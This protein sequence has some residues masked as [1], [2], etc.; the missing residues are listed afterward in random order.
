MS[1]TAKQMQNANLFCLNKPYSLNKVNMIAIDMI[2]L[3]HAYICNNDHDVLSS[4]RRR[5]SNIR[6]AIKKINKHDSVSI[7]DNP[8]HEL[9]TCHNNMSPYTYEALLAAYVKHYS[10][11]HND[12]VNTCIFTVP[13]MFDHRILANAMKLIDMPYTTVYDYIAASYIMSTQIKSMFTV[14]VPNEYETTIATVNNHSFTSVH[15]IPFGA[16]HI[17]EVIKEFIPFKISSNTAWTLYEHLQTVTVVDVSNIDLSINIPFEVT[18]DDLI[19]LLA[20]YYKCIMSVITTPSVIVPFR[21]LNRDNFINKTYTIVHTL[22][23][24]EYICLG[25]YMYINNNAHMNNDADKFTYIN[26][27]NTDYTICKTSYNKLVEDIELNNIVCDYMN[28]VDE[29]LINN[30]ITMEITLTR[31]SIDKVKDLLV[32]YNWEK[33]H[34]KKYIHIKSLIAKLITKVTVQSKS[35]HCKEHQVDASK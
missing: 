20:N 4:V 15:V 12:K 24:D 1:N 28:S 6:P 19:A 32:K 13:H 9:I 3:D 5:R 29:F 7:V 17:K 16:H 2:N 22:N 26:Q 35:T 21:W 25:A 18:Q 27:Y 34:Y 8:S 33:T 23:P 31:A 11:E 30:D 14:I 10:E